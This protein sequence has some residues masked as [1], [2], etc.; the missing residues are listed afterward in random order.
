MSIPFTQHLRPNG[1]KSPIE[2]DMPEDIE[3][4]ARSFIE[5]GGWFDCEVLTT[6][7]VSLTAGFVVNAEPQDIA[8]RIV[9]NGPGIDGA[10]ESLVRE[11]NAY[12]TS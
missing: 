12:R 11:A 3:K 9:P 2:I 8:I 10:V 4:L 6:G 7:D 1:R 5:R